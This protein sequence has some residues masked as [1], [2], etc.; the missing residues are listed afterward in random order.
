MGPWGPRPL[1]THW[2]LGTGALGDPGPW[3][4]I[5]R[6]GTR[7]SSGSTDSFFPQNPR[8]CIFFDVFSFDKSLIVGRYIK[9][10]KIRQKFNK[11]LQ[12]L[13][14]KYTFHYRISLKIIH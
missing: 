7:A 11:L 10:D 6:I 14:C 3:G 13:K 8:T 5:G 1:E 12:T 4:P 9:S 2:P